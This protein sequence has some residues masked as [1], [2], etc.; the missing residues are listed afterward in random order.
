MST[1]Q[2]PN[3]NN[4][5]AGFT[6]IELLL[7]VA[8]V[9]SLLL[10]V[11]AFVILSLD[12]RVKSQAIS[13]VDQQG[14]AI[15][16]QIQ[17]AIKNANYVVSPSPG[18]SAESLSLAGANSVTFSF[19]SDAIVVSEDGGSDIALS[20]SKVKISDLQFTNLSRPGTKGIVK[21]SLTISRVNTSGG[22]EYNYQKTFTTSVTV[23]Q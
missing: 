19:Y 13:E 17:Y 5:L 23:G 18:V 21:V 3:I 15:I 4:R 9:G 22:Q 1:T 14:V 8:I 7:Y 10:A 16:Q 20:N 2:T 6:L 11:V 12:L